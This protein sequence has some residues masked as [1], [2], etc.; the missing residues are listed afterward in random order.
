M[1]AM[2]TL[3]RTLSDGTPPSEPDSVHR[4]SR[5]NDWRMIGAVAVLVPVAFFGGRSALAARDRSKVHVVTNS[6]GFECDGTTVNVE[7][8]E[9]AN[10][11]FAIRTADIHPGMQCRFRFIVLNRAGEDLE[12]D[13]IVFSALGPDWGSAVE[14]VGLAPMGARPVP[15]QRDAVFKVHTSLPAGSTREFVLLLSYRADGCTAEGTRIRF[16]DQ[17][18]VTLR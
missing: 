7:E 14:A 3:K 2:A 8:L 5:L 11:N 6:A 18:T 9:D 4:R 10:A 17:P 1:C 16:S 13:R 12:L 15:G